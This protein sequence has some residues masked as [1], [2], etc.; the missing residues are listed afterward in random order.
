MKLSIHHN[1][2]YFKFEDKDN[3]TEFKHYYECL[4]TDGYVLWMKTN[5]DTDFK[6]L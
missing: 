4:L 3:P 1:L 2:L 5:D 6:Y